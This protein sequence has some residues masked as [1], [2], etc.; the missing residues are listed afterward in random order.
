MSRCRVRVV[1]PVTEAA[2]TDA[3]SYTVKRRRAHSTAQQHVASR[4]PG[5]LVLRD[6]GHR[7]S[8][9]P[10]VARWPR[11]CTRCITWGEPVPWPRS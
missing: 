11:P 7:L 2:V 6:G 9:A 3:V 8:I 4:P 5:A 10:R 1:T